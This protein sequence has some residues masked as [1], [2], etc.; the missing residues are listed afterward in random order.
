M[1]KICTIVNKRWVILIRARAERGARELGIGYLQTFCCLLG[2]K[3]LTVF[4]FDDS[5]PAAEEAA[6]E[7]NFAPGL[8][9]NISCSFS[10]SI[11][12]C[13]MFSAIFF[14]IHRVSDTFRFGIFS[15]YMFFVAAVGIRLGSCGSGLACRYVYIF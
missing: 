12:T 5:A 8:L 10:V 1:K 14:F 6:A 4:D 11:G 9:P 13:L 3:K 7:L 15:Q 2:S